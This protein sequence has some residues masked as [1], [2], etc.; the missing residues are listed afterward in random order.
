M[1]AVLSVRDLHVTFPGPDGPVRA[2]RGVDLDLAAGERV[3]L[4]GESGSG[5]S[6]LA[7]AVLGLLPSGADVTG[8]VLL[9]GR[10]LRTA[11]DLR[12]ARGTRVA[13][14]FQDPLAALNPVRT[15]GSLLGEVLAAAGC[16]SRRAG[17][18]RARDVLAR[19]GLGDVPRALRSYPSQ[20]SGGQ[21]QRVLIAWPSSTNPR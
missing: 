2:V 3:A 11:R 15:V 10:P 20:L 6:V 7:R 12:R 4:V 19:V 17:A 8:Q 9:D 13:M 1:T 16:T 21:R 14:V 18:A 5:K